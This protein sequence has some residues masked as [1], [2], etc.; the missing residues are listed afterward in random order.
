M[1]LVMKYD[2]QTHIHRYSCWAA[3]RAASTSRN[4][5][6]TV[7]TGQNILDNSA[8]RNLILNPDRLPNSDVEFDNQHE[9]WRKE[10]IGCAQRI[11]NEKFTHGIAAKLI[12]IYLKSI[13]ICGGFH[14]HPNSKFIHPPIDSVL[15]KKLIEKKFNRRTEFWQNAQKIAWSSFNSNEYQNVINE[16]RIGLQGAPLW[17]I[18]EFWEGHQ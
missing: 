1:H 17:K 2:I 16:I 9:I 3:S 8:I 5:R 13:I 10:I 7:E 18:E 4:N 14:E 15:L 11:G 6:F 12:N